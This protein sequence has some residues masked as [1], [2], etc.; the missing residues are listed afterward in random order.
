MTMHRGC[1]MYCD[2]W[3]DRCRGVSADKPVTGCINQ[4]DDTD[5][6]SAM[7]VDHELLEPDRGPGSE[8]RGRTGGVATPKRPTGSGRKCCGSFANGWTASGHPVSFN[9]SRFAAAPRWIPFGAVLTIPGYNGGRAVPVLDRGGA[10]KGDR[11]D[12]F[13]PTH[14]AAPKWGV[15][16]LDVEITASDR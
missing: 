6:N 9:G 5:Y 2:D 11:L 13:F 14:N 1:A 15:R 3:P 16:Y 10:I 7:I 8:T 4:A 12:V